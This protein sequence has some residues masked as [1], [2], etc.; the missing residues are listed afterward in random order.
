MPKAVNDWRTTP[1]LAEFTESELCSPEPYTLPPTQRPRITRMQHAIATPRGGTDGGGSGDS[2]RITNPAGGDEQRV[3]GSSGGDDGGGGDSGRKP[4]G[5]DGQQGTGGH[6]SGGRR[7]PPPRVTARKEPLDGSGAL[8]GRGDCPQLPPEL[9]TWWDAMEEDA[10]L[11]RVLIGLLV[12]LAVLLLLV[13][14]LALALCVCLCLARRRRRRSRAL[15]AQEWREVKCVS[16]P[17]PALIRE[18][19]APLETAPVAAHSD[20]HLSLE[21]H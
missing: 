20:P 16:E 8:E 11:H 14:A 5:G 2:G 21:V 9:A 19:A 7:T 6:T 10:R 18:S 13:V 12:G 17:E 3:T 1:R 15:P 4:D